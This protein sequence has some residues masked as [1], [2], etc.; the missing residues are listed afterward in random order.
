MA[1]VARIKKNGT[2]LVSNEIN[3]RLPIIT[4]G[5]I[6]Y[7]PLDGDSN[8]AIT[9]SSPYT[10]SNIIQTNNGV[11]IQQS[12]TN[13]YF[14]GVNSTNDWLNSG[15]PPIINNNDLSI[16]KP[17]SYKNINIR[18]LYLSDVS[19]Y[20]FGFS[21]ISVSPSTQYTLSIWFYQNSIITG[22]NPYA[23][24]NINNNNVGDLKWEVNNSSNALTWPIKKWIRLYTTFTTSSNETGIF[25]SSYP[26]PYSKI[27]MSCPQLEQR[28]FA[29]SFVNGTK[30]D[31]SLSIP[32]SGIGTGNFTIYSEFLPHSNSD[33]LPNNVYFMELNNLIR[34]GTWEQVPFLNSAQI[35]GSGPNIHFDFNTKPGIK[36]RNII[37]KQGNIFNWRIK[38]DDG[39]D[40]TWSLT[41]G[42]IGSF[43]LTSINL[44]NTW[45]GIHSNISVYNKILN[46]SEIEEL[47]G[48]FKVKTNSVITPLLIE[49]TQSD[50]YHYPLISDTKEI[51][52]TFDASSKVNESYKNGGIW[53]GT[54][55]T[56]VVPYNTLIV[57]EPYN[58][59]NIINERIFTL[60]MVTGGALY[61]TLNNNV[62]YYGNIIT[63][64]GY[65]LKNGLPHS[66]PHDRANTY[67]SV[68]AIRWYFDL[69][70]GYFEIVE[71]CNASSVWLFHTPSGALGG[72]VITIMDYQVEIKP[73]ASAFT[74]STR[75]YTNISFNLHSSIGLS[76]ASNWTITYW[77]KPVSTTNDNLIGYNIESLGCNGN[78]VGG[79]YSWWGKQNGSN[80]IS[81][82]T[83]SSFSPN[84]YF[85]KWQFVSMVKIGTNIEIKTTLENGVVYIRNTSSTNS[86]PNYYVTQYGY[87]FKLGGHD[88]SNPSNTY[89]KNLKVFKNI[90]S[91]YELDVQFRIGKNNIYTNNLIEGII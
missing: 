21:I 83:P 65:M 77:K 43:N 4:N 20:H 62:D 70:T 35:I 91:D 22:G 11:S 10:S 42:N 36:C 1:V 31:G 85:N 8:N 23:R 32:V 61:L 5:V 59:L 19:S 74:L 72:D 84:D 87:D 64:S 30:S 26:T 68:P 17:T 79:G 34:M 52:G 3:E 60:T 16:S 89:F 18:S 50:Y 73:F 66:L 55:T 48:S 44:L 63:H 76:W 71:N 78:S 13:L 25:V 14:T 39:Q 6:L 2:L 56:N 24:Q 38:S 51:G 37:T 86:V 9:Y 49:T 75:G 58:T 88:N 47:G 12:T 54:T 67:H 81:S 15:V 40:V 33:N 27:Y 57:H 69:N 90:L 7:Y 45:S 53:V 80:D 46:S 28:S 29:T 82:S 41:H